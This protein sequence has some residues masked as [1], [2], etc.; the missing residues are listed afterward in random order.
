M[1]NYKIMNEM[2]SP[3]NQT[4]SSLNEK[5]R[6]QIIELSQLSKELKDMRF[7]NPPKVLNMIN[8]QMRR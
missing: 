8:G 6:T 1:Q 4:L 2:I 7:E 3:V 5:V